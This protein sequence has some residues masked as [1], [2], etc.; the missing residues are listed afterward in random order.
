MVCVL[1]AL[2]TL[3]SLPLSTHLRQKHTLAR[4]QNY[5]KLG[6]VTNNMSEQQRQE[7]QK[8]PALRGKGLKTI[9]ALAC[10]SKDATAHLCTYCRMSLH[11]LR[12]SRR[13]RLAS[14]GPPKSM[15]LLA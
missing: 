14:K 13:N 1:T 9:T 12:N 11:S 10:M 5:L 7:G 3:I 8:H 2:G 15:R 4:L 6:L